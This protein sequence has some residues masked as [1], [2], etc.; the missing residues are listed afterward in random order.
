MDLDF[1]FEVTEFDWSVSGRFLEAIH[2]LICQRNNCQR[3]RN[4]WEACA[5]CASIEFNIHVQLICVRNMSGVARW[6]QLREHENFFWSSWHLLGGKESFVLGFH[7]IDII[8]NG[9]EVQTHFFGYDLVLHWL[10]FGLIFVLENIH[11]KDCPSLMAKCF[12]DLEILSD[13]KFNF[14]NF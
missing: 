13:L 14:F 3:H 1:E 4:V 10:N 6:G 12:L 5:A 9:S 11:T 7:R 2:T 8:S